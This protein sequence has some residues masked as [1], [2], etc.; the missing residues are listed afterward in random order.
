MDS[1]GKKEELK[2]SL[3][4]ARLRFGNHNKELQPIPCLQ[5]P[6]CQ[7]ACDLYCISKDYSVASQYHIQEVGTFLCPC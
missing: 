4:L 7:C 5:Y 1:V 2:L 6:I 3:L